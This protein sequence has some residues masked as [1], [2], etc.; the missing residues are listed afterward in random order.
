MA[1]ARVQNQGSIKHIGTR[2]TCE[3]KPL[4]GCRSGL[5]E[6]AVVVDWIAFAAVLG[7]NS[8]ATKI[9]LAFSKVGSHLGPESP[10]R[11][12]TRGGPG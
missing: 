5:I 12:H 2:R 6:C 1:K 9:N 3:R 8:G 11:S 4:S 7:M 10:M